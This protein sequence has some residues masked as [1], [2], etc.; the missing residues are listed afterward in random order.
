MTSEQQVEY[1]QK[2]ADEL[3]ASCLM[4]DSKD[5]KGRPL[6]VKWNIDDLSFDKHEYRSYCQ[7]DPYHYHNTN[8]TCYSCYTILLEKIDNVFDKDINDIIIENIIIKERLERLEK[9]LNLK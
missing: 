2:L 4:K 6:A 8:G 1:L 3:N 5:T 9:L 7:L